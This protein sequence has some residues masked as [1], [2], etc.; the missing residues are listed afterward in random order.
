M[1]L[2]ASYLQQMLLQP[3]ISSFVSGLLG[4][5]LLRCSSLRG[6]GSG[7]FLKKPHTICGENRK[8]W[9]VEGNTATLRSAVGDQ[10]L[11]TLI[12]DYLIAK[13][14]LGDFELKIYFTTSPGTGAFF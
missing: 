7:F 4:D 14:L 8:R 10:I 9:L 2:I 1:V 6:A 5:C 3:E 11:R 13:P 12:A